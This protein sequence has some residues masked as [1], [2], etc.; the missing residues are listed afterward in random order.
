MPSHR[1]VAAFAVLVAACPGGSPQQKSGLSSPPHATDT[2]KVVE[3]E[4]PGLTFHLAEGVEG[5]DKRE[6]T[7]PA[8]AAP[9]GD[10]DTK[11]VIDRLPALVAKEG[12]EKPFAMRE[13]SLPPPRTGATVK[14]AF[15]PVEAP[16]APP[17]EEAGPLRVLRHQ[18]EGD[19]P[20]APHVAITFSQPMVPV[21]SLA[22]IEKMPVPAKLTPQ[23]PGRWRWIGAKTLLYEPID[24]PPTPGRFPMATDYTVDI[25]AGV[26]S[27]NGGTLD[28]AESFRFSTPT[29]RV[30][31]F[32]PQTGPTR[33]DPI[34]FASFDQKIDAAAVLETIHVRAGGQ[35]TKLRL[36]TADEAKADKGVKGFVTALEAEGQTGRYVAFAPAAPLP[37]DA[38]VTVSIGPG[39]P[40]AE[41]PKKTASAQ[42]FSFRTYGAMRI[43]DRTCQS[44]RDNCAPGTPLGVRFSNPIEAGKLAKSMVTIEPPIPG[45]KLV[46]SGDYLSI[47][48]ITRGRSRYK[49]TFSGRIPDE[50][51]QTMGKDE[52]VT[53]V[54]VAAPKSVFA[55]G[56]ELVVLDPTGGPKFSVY[57]INHK[58]I[59]VKAWAK[60]PEDWGAFG[61]YMRETWY[62]EQ[63]PADPPGTPAIN[64]VVT[65]KGDADELA[66]TRIDLA[67]VLKDGRGSALL[68]IEPT[69]RPKNR[70]EWTPVIVWVQATH[71]GLTGFLD[72]QNLEAWATALGDGK[73]LEG[74]EVLLYPQGATGRTDAGGM[75]TLPLGGGADMLIAKV[76]DD[77]AFLPSARSIWDSGSRWQRVERPDQLVWYAADDRRMYRPGEEVKLKGWIR[78]RGAGPKGGI[79]GARAER[80]DWSL[81]D[82][83]GNDVAKGNA[84]LSALGGFDFSVKLPPT[85]NLG[86][87]NFSLQAVGASAGNGYTSHSIQVQEFRRPEFEVAAKTNDGPFFVGGRA[88]V[89]VT[90]SY[91]AGGGLGNAETHWQV[92]S[93]PGS[94]IPPNRGDYLFG[95]QPSWWDYYTRT[96]E[97]GYKSESFQAVTD[98][99]GKHVLRIDF[100][101][102]NPPRPMNVTAQ[103]S[104]MD[105]NRQ[106]WT[107][108]ANLLVHPADRYVGVKLARP[109]LQKG[110]PIK[111]DTIVTDLDGKMVPKSDVEVRAVR[112]DWDY[113]G[114][115]YKTKDV[116]PQ[117]CRVVS[118]ENPEKCQFDTKEGGMYK[119]SAIVKDARGRKNLTEVKVWVAG[120][121]L[122]PER[123]VTKEKVQLL[124]DKKEYKAGDTAEIM[125]IAPW[126]P[127]EAA[128]TLRREGIFKT[129][130]LTLSEPSTTLKVPIDEAWTPNVTVQ[131][132]LVGAA[133]RTNDQ[134]EADPKLPKRPAY[135]AGQVSLSIPPLQRKLALD[136]KPA[137]DKV[138]PGAQTAV[139]VSLKDARGEP[140]A[141]GEV[142]VVIVDE[143]VL[144]LTGYKLADPLPLFY[145]YRGPGAYDVDL[146]EQVVLAAPEE[147]AQPQT[148]S[149]GAMR[150]GHRA[151]APGAPPPPP[152]AAPKPMMVKAEARAAPEPEQPNAP[153]K[154]RTDFS[155]L[156]LFAPRVTTDARGRADVPVKLP[157]NLTRYR[158]MAIAVAGEKQFGAGESTITARL[159]LMV[160]PSPP[161]FLNFG[162]RFELPVVLQNQT[163]AP[164]DVDVAVR[165]TNLEL[166]AGAGR[167]VTVPANDRVE[168]RFPAAAVK[169]GI[170]RFQLGA[171]AVKNT[172]WSDA[173]ELSLPV[174][175]PATSEAFATYGV[176]DQG[177]IAQP[178]KMPAGVF[179]QFGG[180]SVTT[181]STAVQALTDAVLYLVRYPY[182]CS[183][184]FSSRLMAVAGLKDVL[185]A[186]HAEGMPSPAVMLESVTHDVEMLRRLQNSDGGWGFWKRGEDSWAFVS[187]HVAHALQRAKEKGF[188]VP[189]DMIQRALPYLK[190]IE[191][192][193]P[194]IYPPDV[195]RAIVAY[196]LYT[197]NRLGDRD[198]AKARRLIAEAGGVDKLPIEAVA[199]IYPVLS[200][201]QASTAELQSVR[202]LVGNR[203]E[204]TAGAAHFTTSYA[205]GNYLLLH[206]DRRVDALFLEAL[207]LDQPKT[208]VI[209]KLV[210]GLLG[211]RVRGRWNSTQENAWVL[212]ALDKYFN[213]Y[214]KVTPDFVARAW[215][216][217]QFA[218]DHAF[219][220]RTTERYAIDIPMQWL[221]DKAGKEQN[222]VLQK[223]GAGRMYYRVGMD[224]APT[225]LKLPPRDNGFTVTREYES[226]DDKADVRRDPDGT[227]HVKAGARVRVRL[228]MVAQARRYHVALVDPLPAGLEPM[229][230]ALKVTGEVPPDPKDQNGPGRWRWW[231]RWY[232]HENLRDERVEAFT[233]LLWDGVHTY[234]YV[235]RA[236]TPG[237]FVVPPTKAE[238]MYSPETFGRS[239]GD[240]LVVE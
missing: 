109:F 205:D 98:P 210:E 114:G 235:A 19:V 125:V 45:F 211:H 18:P 138:E 118:S 51:G 38:Q 154:V 142:A 221:A 231:W 165:V 207:I 49:V 172:R 56:G 159:P 140:V 179:P 218:G 7:P 184:Q 191:R 11:K 39:T 14:G 188:D 85:M 91:F 121:K 116:D 234:S 105:V 103:G 230:P 238:E 228:T 233:T 149:A 110:E 9:L 157:D 148:G 222:L 34:M 77:L 203:I 163:D 239:G 37:V 113:E 229:N 123:N 31:T 52:T 8:K 146:R 119:V 10:A 100:L 111:L 117:D 29:V 183:E 202:K 25:A 182:E 104:V 206:S 192:H 83:R 33:R 147:L 82:S 22:E 201:D 96:R 68:L 1:R 195:R 67:R 232:Q 176:V 215:L 130:R 43:V 41:G 90:A 42:E 50:F 240:K 63:F 145:G 93:S 106:A 101:A 187:I 193:I 3:T 170:A 84:E 69:V 213:T 108:T 94:F 47:I 129:D 160:R 5:A 61:K 4:D 132:D 194:S 181:S 99:S 12:D 143:A 107:A 166:G 60:R 66:E 126:A 189:A 186:F 71:I 225:D 65:V 134:G 35:E 70:W 79:A 150:N 208:D 169:A 97:G 2:F 133:P 168:V 196:S 57:S 16:P 137:E 214:E 152:S 120:G 15:P 27:Q 112:Q 6:V 171:V 124:P 216:G 87:A 32:H 139:T 224:Y 20:L 62:R 131:V 167:R 135:A 44:D 178:V 64:E 180:L 175:T 198:A 190:D 136:V 153:I 164:M 26:K 76:G 75:A 128:V 161:R 226:V 23:P 59:R 227:W 220:G 81:R 24:N 151:M 174:W 223:D 204:E 209:P 80:I 122:P 199:W 185:S 102:A 158:V 86:Y 173:A 28:K 212:L 46:P 73:P 58:E 162:D 36:A 78:T 21:T 88:I 95:I 141:G 89:S 127:A 13:R 197:R 217:P 48:G 55:M 30:A 156:A 236:T 54:T 200:G 40:S 237:T 17:P 219:K 115:E 144:S 155:A 177:S 92:S 53:F 74:A 72:D